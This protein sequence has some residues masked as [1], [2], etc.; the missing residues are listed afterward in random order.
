MAPPGSPKRPRVLV[1]D[2]EATNIKLLTTMMR[3]EGYEVASAADGQEALAQ[4]AAA[5]PDLILLDVMMPERDGYDVCRQLKQQP[6]TRL[7]PIVL[8]TALGKEEHRLAGIEAGADDFLTK[9]IS[10]TELRARVRSLLKLKAFT[11]ELEHAHFVLRSL[12]LTLD[13]RSRYTGGHSKRVAAAAMA[14]A[15][16]LGLTGPEV[17]SVGRGGF[18]HDLGKVGIPDAILLKP[19][20]L[21]PEERIVIERHPVIGADLVQPLKTFHVVAPIIRHHHERW[22]GTGYPD[23]LAE[24]A[25]PLGAQIVGLLDVYDALTTARAYRPA[26]TS[27]EALQILRQERADGRWRA[28]LVE[29]F[30]ALT[31]NGRRRPASSRSGR[32]RNGRR[33]SAVG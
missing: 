22:D 23:G 33:A 18:L 26:L 6:E 2:D 14:L 16:A 10:G 24:D 20:S 25:I 4:V 11:D 7:V 29:A 5:T 27:P 30:L 17:E 28:D 1:V 32:G 9:P 21:T 19:G 15:E 3:S 12:A 13:A 8:I 31:E